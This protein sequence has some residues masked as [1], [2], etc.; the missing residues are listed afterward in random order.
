MSKP[1]TLD[2]VVEANRP[3]YTEGLLYRY[4]PKVGFQRACAVR[5]APSWLP[6]PWPAQADL[7][8]YHE[9]GCDCCFCQP[10][11]VRVVSRERE[12]MVF[13]AR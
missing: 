5:F 1:L 6:V 9:D 3:A 11:K 4:L 8:W 10:R 2:G 7:A 13:S 12:P